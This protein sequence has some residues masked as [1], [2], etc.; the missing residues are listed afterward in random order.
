MVMMVST[1]GVAKTDGS[2]A[3]GNTFQTGHIM[4]R[5]PKCCL[6]DTHK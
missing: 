5:T 2:E 6:H 1:I 3:S 4:S